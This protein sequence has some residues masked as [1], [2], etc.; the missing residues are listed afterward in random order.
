M[1]VIAELHLHGPVEATKEPGSRLER[2]GSR[3]ARRRS[4]WCRARPATRRSRMRIYNRAIGR[5]ESELLRLAPVDREAL[6]EAEADASNDPGLDDAARA[7][8][9]KAAETLARRE[10]DLDKLNDLAL[11]GFTGPDSGCLLVSWPHTHTRSSP[12]GSGED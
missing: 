5:R 10:R 8:A 9:R 4:L 7:L 3:E 11:N 6:D 1:Y 12:P 2:R